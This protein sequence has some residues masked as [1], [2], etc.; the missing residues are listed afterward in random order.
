VVVAVVSIATLALAWYW[1]WTADDAFITF[2][3]VR[4][5]LNG[6]GPVFN[7]GERV[8]VAT[9]PLWLWLLAGV[10]AVLPV[11]VSWIAVV[12]GGVGSA[13]GLALACLGTAALHPPVGDAG[14][15]RLLLPAGALVF[16]SV[17]ATWAFLTSGLETGL[18]FAWL[19]AVWFGTARVAA[20][21]APTRPLWL[22]VVVG[23]GPLV[24]PDLAIVTGLVGLWLLVAVPSG[25]RRRIR[26]VLVAGAL[27]LAYQVFRMGW[28][29]LL[30]PN[31]AVAKESGRSLWSRGWEYLLDLVTPYDLYVPAA[32]CAA[33]LAVS[34]LTARWDR[35]V[36]GLVGVTLLAA[37]LQT[38][39]VVRVGGDFMHGR[40]LL[41]ALFQALC[42]VAVVPLALPRAG[43]A[44]LPRWL[45]VALAAGL[46]AWAAVCALSLRIPYPGAVGPGGIADERAFYV[47]TTPSANPVTVGDH[48]AGLPEAW[49][50]QVGR[51][52]RGGFDRVYAENFTAGDGTVPRLVPLGTA[53]GTYFLVYHAGY[54]GYASPDDVIVLDFYGL[55]D[56][57][58]SHLEAPPPLRPGHEKVLPVTWFWARY[59]DR[60]PRL[61]SPDPAVG[62]VTAGSLAAARDALAC[63]ELAE[64]VAATSAPMTWDRFWA[65]L[66][67]SADRTALRIPA[68]PRDAE[69]E[70]C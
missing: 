55:A 30:V 59:A 16:L 43:R 46:L 36:L 67:G 13:A 48:G 65:N 29:G 47:R 38:A 21:P 39:F 12:L 34:A 37:A 44:A 50:E 70:F 64:L 49:G 69:A 14:S 15:R 3:A 57:V 22:L 58:G 28:F 62:R 33:L 9:S 5:V 66:T 40:L 1:R 45:S 2:R 10:A 27:P 6:D 53:N 19:G 63:G 60:P 68:D 52:A 54:L 20:S 35:R 23:L 56:P 17:P 24:R 51:S 18:I 11:D 61:Q 32:L 8:E 25:W 7:A 31:T 41:P 4:S 42:P 26:D